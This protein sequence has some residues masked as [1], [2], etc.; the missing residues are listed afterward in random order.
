MRL[1]RKNT[2]ANIQA[3]VLKTAVSTSDFETPEE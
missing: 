1:E 3:T 2:I